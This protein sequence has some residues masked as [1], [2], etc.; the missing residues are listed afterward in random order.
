MTDTPK[1]TPKGKA[2]LSAW[3]KL[4]TATEQENRVRKALIQRGLKGPGPGAPLDMLEHALD[5]VVGKVRD[6]QNE[7]AAALDAV[8]VEG[9]LETKPVAA[10][11]PADIV[12]TTSFPPKDE[13]TLSFTISP[14][15]FARIAVLQG[16]NG[17]VPDTPMDSAVV[18][19]DGVQIGE[20]HLVS[21]GSF[22]GVSFKIVGGLHCNYKAKDFKTVDGAVG[23][24]VAMS[25]LIPPSPKDD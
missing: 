13:K 17:Y 2:V 8:G 19:R 7:V 3:Q 10:P 15:L 9:F 1:I 21:D 4:I 14:K 25:D 23:W 6:A 11:K 12:Q 18:A 20:V 16:P 22:L 24:L 5:S